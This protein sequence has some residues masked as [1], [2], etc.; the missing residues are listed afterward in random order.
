MKATSSD[1]EVGI[2]R[3]VNRGGSKRK[4]VIDEESDDDPVIEP[5][6]KA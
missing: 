3:N 4:R 1:D 2:K 5:Q 6:P